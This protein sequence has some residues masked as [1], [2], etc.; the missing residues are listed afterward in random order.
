[1]KGLAVFAKWP[2]SG[3]YYPGIVEELTAADWKEVT[4][5]TVKFYDGLVRDMKNINI[6]P[7][8]LIP[9]GSML[10]DL[11]DETEMV[12]LSCDG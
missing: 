11:E 10:C 7:A 4:N 8:Y 12:V 3:W 6:L 1:M 5:V 9:A 2:N